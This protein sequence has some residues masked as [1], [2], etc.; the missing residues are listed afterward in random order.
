MAKEQRKLHPNVNHVFRFFKH[1]TSDEHTVEEIVRREDISRS[2]QRLASHLVD[3][4]E[5]PEATVCLRKL[6]EAKEAA[7]RAAPREGKEKT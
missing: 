1:T 2:F 4:I 7:L 3:R 5:G 6:L